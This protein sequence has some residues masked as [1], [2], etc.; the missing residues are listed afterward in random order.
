MNHPNLPKISS[1]SGKVGAL[2]ALVRSD[3]TSG[4][5]FNHF[6]EDEGLGSKT[7]QVVSTLKINERLHGINKVEESTDF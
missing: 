4:A 1:E 3:R 6:F 5:I 7:L 2:T